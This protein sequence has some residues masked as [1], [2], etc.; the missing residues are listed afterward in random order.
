MS[1]AVCLLLYSFAVA[2]LSPRVLPRL[3]HGGAAPRLGVAAWLVMMVS[4]VASWQA[5]T[6]FLIVSLVR[7]WHQPGRLATACLESLGRLV[8]G[9]AAAALQGALLVLAAAAVS[10]L[11]T[12]GW[13]SGRSLW[14]A[15]A[16]SRGHAERARVIGRRIDGVDAVV[17]DAAERAAYCV[18]GR[19]DTVVVTSAALD[20]L[21]DRNLQAVL[22]HERAHLAGRHHHVL[23]FAR[24]L[25]VAIPG[26]ALFSTGDREIS[27]LLEMAADDVAAR[28]YGSL[29]LLD[30]L[31]ALSMDALA[32]QGAFGATGIDMLARAE[33]LAAPPA[34][35]NRWSGRLLLTATTLLISVGPLIP[36][37]LTAAGAMWCYPLAG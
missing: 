13:R 15:R 19:P 30:A 23:A 1:V 3:T 22:A 25:A 18:A 17:V 4:V 9:G 36:A 32:P 12:L 34:A 20:S 26:V 37:A 35:R 16:Q 7:Y 11:S 10:A 8:D 14:R 33:R 21:T 28:K 2:T 31:L 5:A 24:A 29:T 27:L 6:A